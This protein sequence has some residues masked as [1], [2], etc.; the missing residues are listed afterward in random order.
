VLD[1]LWRGGHWSVRQ[2]LDAVGEPLAY[3]TIATVLDR[4]H[5]K[6]RVDRTKVGNAWRYH[7]RRSREQ[8]LAA[9]VGR[10]LERAKGAP[11]PLLVAFLDRMEEVDPEALDRLE[12]LIRARKGQA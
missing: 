7:A 5:D 12:A 8:A 1:V 9:E 11:D 4:L 2:V 3:T 6:G 10:V